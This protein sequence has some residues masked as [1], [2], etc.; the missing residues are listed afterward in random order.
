MSQRRHTAALQPARDPFGEQTAMAW[1]MR[2]QLLGGKFQFAGESQALLRLLEH[3]YGGLPPPRRRLLPAAPAFR[4]MLRSSAHRP[5]R[6]SAR[7]PPLTMRSGPASLLCAVMDAG[8]FS[9]VSPAERTGLIVVSPDLLSSPEA[10][11]QLLEFAVFTLAARTQ[12]LV[13]LHAACVGRAGRGLLLMGS[14]GAG[15]STVAL[16]CLLQGLE[17]LAEDEVLVRPEQ[18]LATGASNFLHLRPD[19]LRLLDDQTLLALARKSPLIQRRNGARKLELN[20]RLLGRRLAR[21]PL[22]ID[23]IVFLSD[24]KAGSCATVLPLPGRELLARLAATQPRAA[25]LPSWRTF[26]QQLAGIQGFEL[27]RGTHPAESALALRHILEL[28][29]RTNLSAGP[30]R[31]D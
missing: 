18:L 26:R 23:G 30:G 13:P 7:L 11:Y 6:R 4:I 9:V 10:C 17:F 31:G 22:A 24:R 8:N 21:S 14:S 1:R 20:L 19:S 3:C 29:R 2:L 5:S 15:K 28:G 25:H 16:H 27:R 12:G